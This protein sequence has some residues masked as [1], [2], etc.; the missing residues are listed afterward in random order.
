MKPRM[1]GI[2]PSVARG[3]A[4]M[5]RLSKVTGRSFEQWRAFIGQEGPESSRERL[6]WLKKEHGLGG[7]Y[8]D[9][10]V[11]TVDGQGG[12]R[13][14]DE[15]YLAM[16]PRYVE[17]MFAGAKEE[18]IPAYD[19][20][21]DVATSLGSDVRPAPCR[22]FVP[23]YRNHVFAQVKPASHSRIDL[24]LVLS[25]RQAPAPMISTGGFEKGD[26]ITHR[27]PIASPEDVNAVVRDWLM[28]AY[29]LDS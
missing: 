18:L 5:G 24:G 14:D 8:A 11:A 15:A 6:A 26:R 10:L 4:M 9:L 3:R 28:R 1:F 21:L 22:T 16:A 12:E 25:A 19:R 20:L 23:L 27:I 7:N 2:H 29:E 13:H 17:A